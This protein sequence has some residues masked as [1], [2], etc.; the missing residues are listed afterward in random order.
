M[1]K[2]KE[3]KVEDFSKYNGWSWSSGYD[4]GFNDGL[5]IGFFRGI[6]IGACAIGII[7]ALI[8]WIK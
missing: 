7:I 5:T 3:I 6:G 4:D 1:R 8:E 2:V